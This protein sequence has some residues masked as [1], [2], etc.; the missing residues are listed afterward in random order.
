M[1]DKEVREEPGNTHE[2]L[3]QPQAE[4]PWEE[5]G[6]EARNPIAPE[7]PEE[8]LPSPAATSAEGG[9][10]VMPTVSS[11]QEQFL[12]ASKSG[13]LPLDVQPVGLSGLEQ[14]LNGWCRGRRRAR[15]DPEPSWP[16]RHGGPQRG[17]RWDRHDYCG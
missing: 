1:P 2:L 12:I 5:A 13:P 16:C 15:Q 7:Q 11:R 6:G 17:N 3:E 9:R 14:A 4:A 8:V 10:K